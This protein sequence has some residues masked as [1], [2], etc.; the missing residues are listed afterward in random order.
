M[1]TIKFSSSRFKYL[2]LITALIFFIIIC[3]L[4]KIQIILNNNFYQ[5]GERNFLRCEKIPS[6]RGNITDCLGRLLATNKPI[7]TVYW[8]GSGQK[9]LTNEQIS[10]IKEVQNI[11]DLSTE[12]IMN[13]IGKHEKQEKEYLLSKDVNFEQ[14]SQIIEKFPNNPNIVIK[15][16]F[17][18]YYPYDSLASHL[19]GYLS[20]MDIESTGKMGIELAFEDSLKGKDG[21]L[22]K[23]I[24]SKGKKL[25]QQ[26]M[27]K[28][29]SGDTIETTLNLDLQKIAEEEF[30]K[31]ESGACIILD[32]ET[33]AIKTLLSRP[34]F[35]PNI[36]L[37]P[38]T[39]AQWQEMKEKKCFVNRAFNA[40][41]PP[42]SL[43]KLVTL[44]AALET[45]LITE[46]TKWFCPGSITFAGRVIQCHKHEGHG[47]INTQQA[48]MYSCNIPFYEI[49][50]RLNIDTLAEYAQ[51]L[52]LG[53][54]TSDIFAEKAGLVPT[55][56]W[57]KQ[58][59]GSRWFAGE[60]LSA[61][62]GQS[63]YLVTPI[64]IACMISSIC[65]GYW[66]KPEILTNKPV[67]KRHLDISQKTLNFLK[68]SLRQVIRGG[69]G[70]GLN[71]LSNIVIYGKTG[72]AQT[73]DLSKRDLGKKYVEHGY[74]AAYF[75]YKN[76]KPLT[77]V[78]LLENVGS[79]QVATKLALNII[80]KY[81]ES[82]D[83]EQ[84]S[85]NNS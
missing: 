37:D 46:N 39:N 45:G 78:I 31:E 6:P 4:Y 1:E 34:T 9:T 83:K 61:A 62:I 43:F 12:D 48:L 69:T 10:T 28:A 23:T 73:S 19:I 50:K 74:F 76:H 80:L 27:E 54:K 49:G 42:A 60:T 20:N 66:V 18:R 84:N 58:T 59:I 70:K 57:K 36:F 29:L 38:I 63:Y 25:N 85:T 11:L 2:I 40:C 81:C 68:Q 13:E 47:V 71:R 64:Q 8:Q 5:Q 22:I 26:E 53:S 44:A 30:P 3:N 72:T 55:S 32:P 82:I 77:L 79:S 51:K 7:H 15:Q 75:Q 24:N 67:I 33:G 65:Q 56:L 17:K 21:K 41:Y 35:N 52:G 16:N 14:L